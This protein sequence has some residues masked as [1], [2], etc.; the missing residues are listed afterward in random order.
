M[1][2]LCYFENNWI[3]LNFM[4]PSVRY[5]LQ[6]WAKF[7]QIWKC[8]FILCE[9]CLWCRRGSVICSHAMT[10]SWLW[11][12]VH[13]TP[14]FLCQNQNGAAFFVVP[15]TCFKE[16]ST[17]FYE[18][19]APPLTFVMW[20]SVVLLFCCIKHSLFNFDI[21]RVNWSDLICVWKEIWE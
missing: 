2:H 5:N 3:N 6:F 8:V 18:F 21:E 1:L 11:I 9:F 14:A 17:D 16:Y 4:F 20:K 7:L 15:N 13:P 10:V 19:G 12:V